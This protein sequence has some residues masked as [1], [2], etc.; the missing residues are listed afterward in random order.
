M[1][2]I[3]LYLYIWVVYFEARFY[4]AYLMIVVKYK[5]YLFTYLLYFTF[6]YLLLYLYYI[7]DMRII[8]LHMY[9]IVLP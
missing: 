4:F 5:V 7:H 2:Y 1:W 3:L 9:I 8:V 6:F